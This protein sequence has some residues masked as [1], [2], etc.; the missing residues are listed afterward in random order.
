MLVDDLQRVLN[1]YGLG[2]LRDALRIQHGFINDNWVVGTSRGRYFLKRRHPSQRNLG[3]VR[4]QHA[5]VAHLRAAGF[6]APALIPS[7]RGETFLT[8]G[9]ECYEIQNY[10]DGT[11]YQHNRSAHFL[12]AALTLGRYHACVWG[13]TSHTLSTLGELYTPAVLSANIDRLVTAWG[14]ARD[15]SVAPIIR[16]LE[17]HVA[18]LMTRFSRHGTLPELVI[19]GDYYADNLLFRDDRLVGVVDHDKARWQPRVA[20]LAE[21][22]IYVS[23]PRSGHLKH[24]VYPG[25][26]AWGSFARFIRYYRQAV[27]LEES[28]VY[29]LP[30]YVRCIWLVMSLQ[31][32]WERGCP[33][34][35]AQGALGEVLE[36]GTWACNPC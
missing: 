32:L 33:A 25:F 18:D 7:D 22:L 23:S 27:T 16:Q 15:P 8:L 2:E 36:L 31:R 11:R 21:A 9:E 12:E 14:P 26:L 30:D 10:I 6:P 1:E 19:H 28:E 24:L 35:E 4:A 20:E 29:A 3:V 34:Q 5:L 13:F 17:A